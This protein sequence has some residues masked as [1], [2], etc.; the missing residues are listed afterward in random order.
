[1]WKLYGNQISVSI[2]LWLFFTGKI[3]EN[4]FSLP[5]Y[6]YLHNILNFACLPA[7]SQICTIWPF[8]QKACW[9]LS[10]SIH[11]A[12]ESKA[13][14]GSQQS[15]CCHATQGLNLC[16][17]SMGEMFYIQ[18]RLRLMHQKG[19]RICLG[20]SQDGNDPNRREMYRHKANSGRKQLPSLL[21]DVMWPR[22]DEALRLVPVLSLLD[23]TLFIPLLSSFHYWAIG[24]LLR[25]SWETRKEGVC[26]AERTALSVP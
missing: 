19:R 23:S 13:L 16:R 15:E 4:V 17:D 14:R 6:K 12:L 20:L 9:P 5:F 1:M 7:K 8:T 2:M 22:Y 26:K 11:S 21:G 3:C 24:V 18:K 10:G 25:L